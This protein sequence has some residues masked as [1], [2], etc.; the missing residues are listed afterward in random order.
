MTIQLIIKSPSV[1]AQTIYVPTNAANHAVK[2]KHAGNKVVYELLEQ[3]TYLAPKSIQSERVGD[4]LHIRFNGSADTDLVIE[5]Y[6][7]D[8]AVITG[9]AE[10]GQYYTYVPANGEPTHAIAAL[11][12]SVLATHVLGGEAIALGSELPWGWIGVGVLSATAL[13]F[14]LSDKGDT[15]NHYTT[16]SEETITVTTPNP[17]LRVYDINKLN[18]EEQAALQAEVKKL[19]PT[20]TTVI[21]DEQGFV[22]LSYPNGQTRTISPQNTVELNS[23]ARTE[24]E[25][26]T[27][28]V[29]N[30]AHLRDYDINN[31]ETAANAYKEKVNAET[32]DSNR[33]IT[34]VS[35][36]NKTGDIT[37]VYGDN[38]KETV[39]AKQ[40]VQ[41]LPPAQPSVKDDNG[42][43]TFYLGD[44]ESNPHGDGDVATLVFTKPNEA[45]TTVILTYNANTE[46]WEDTS[47][48]LT[49]EQLE[50]INTKGTL[51]LTEKE[52][53]DGSEISINVA[54]KTQ[55]V[56]D[57][58][59]ATAFAM[60][61]VILEELKSD[62]TAV[63]PNN[64]EISDGRVRMIL[65][66]ESTDTYKIE[67]G[68]I[69]TLNGQT[70]YS[71]GFYFTFTYN[72]S[73]WEL[74]S[75]TLN[76]GYTY[77]PETGVFI[78]ENDDYNKNN[79]TISATY[80]NVSRSNADVA[81]QEKQEATSLKLQS[82]GYRVGDSQVDDTLVFVQD[83]NNIDITEQTE[84]LNLAKAINNPKAEPI[85]YYLGQES[86]GYGFQYSFINVETGENGTVAKVEVSYRDGSK[87]IVTIPVAEDLSTQSYNGTDADDIVALSTTASQTINLGNGNDTVIFAADN[88]NFSL[89]NIQSA[90]NIKIMGSGNTLTLS[91]SDL[92][93]NGSNLIIN[94]NGTGNKVKL[95]SSFTQG[96]KDNGYYTYSNGTYTLKIETDISVETL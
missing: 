88:G 73:K 84:I 22:I 32:N 61:N 69:I 4:D 95:D 83:I 70:E 36:N 14:A 53:Q 8:P 40:F 18:Q 71:R 91:L 20:A 43:V 39:E 48:K 87:N 85:T 54:D 64:H 94:D 45:E 33:K 51:T 26:E 79:D 38:S 6:Y 35:V 1:A 24:P 96:S 27:V 15:H 9:L 76:N 82:T 23:A 11:N 37:I 57:K 68:D 58:T 92:T 55:L 31:L 16:S 62:G 2:I 25:I 12:Q 17:V 29:T 49:P 10:N 72:N 63:D 93:D 60:P 77:D 78:L 7:R 81:Y 74:T 67:N 13:L 89:N 66:M 86:D 3:D 44:K 50:E 34:E 5:Q 56:S 80:N 52:V 47:S 59:H 28:A 65:P 46:K 41:D 30:P 90:E 42:T 19:N 21:V 75:K